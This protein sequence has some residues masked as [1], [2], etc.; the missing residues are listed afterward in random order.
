MGAMHPVIRE[1]VAKRKLGK[2][3]VD[4][5]QHRLVVL[6]AVVVEHHQNL[7]QLREH[8]ERV[9]VHQVRVLQ[10]DVRRQQG[11]RHAAAAVHR[12]QAEPAAQVA[13]E[14]QPSAN[15]LGRHE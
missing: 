6:V 13:D 5:D 7:L 4:R 9:P 12:V 8:V 14:V 1:L 10:R 3:A 15:K 2:A 11:L